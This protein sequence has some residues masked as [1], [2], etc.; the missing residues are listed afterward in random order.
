MKRKENRHHEVAQ[1]RTP[2]KARKAKT[3]LNVC[4]NL[5]LHFSWIFLGN[6]NILLKASLTR[7]YPSQKEYV[8]PIQISAVYL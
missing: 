2:R 5:R 7:R 3:L 1:T 8:D 4:I 6:L